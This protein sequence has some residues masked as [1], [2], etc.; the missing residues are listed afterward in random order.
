MDLFGYLQHGR[1]LPTGVPAGEEN[2]PGFWR[3]FRLKPG[4]TVCKVCARPWTDGIR[5]YAGSL[6]WCQL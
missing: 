6:E 1:R 4:G 3:R 2:F 5:R